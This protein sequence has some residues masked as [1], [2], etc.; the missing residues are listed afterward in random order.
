MDEM[1]SPALLASPIKDATIRCLK[2]FESI[3]D[4]ARSEDSSNAEDNLTRF[5]IWSGNIGAHHGLPSRGSADF[6]LREAP[7]VKSRIL[8]LLDDIAETNNELS[9]IS[10][11]DNDVEFTSDEFDPVEELCLSVSDSITSLMKVSALLRKATNRD[12]YAQALASKHDALPL[13]YAGFDRRHVAEKFPKV[14]QQQWLYDRL[15]NAITVRRRFLRYAQRHQKRIAHEPVDVTAGQPGELAFRLAPS[16]T[17]KSSSAPKTATATALST[18][19]STLQ[20]QKLA[21]LD[22]NRL[23]D[24]DDDNISQATS[25]VSEAGPDDEYMSKVIELDKL[26]KHREPFECPYCHGMVQFRN[27]R[28]WR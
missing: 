20:V 6:R 23:D 22:L 18:A 28:A 24:D 8:E 26:T 27:Q 1:S 3:L 12:R 9:A 2:G 19:A 7:E 5:R 13:E 17:P 10:N 16:Q 14:Q 25:F 11:R 21:G 4:A 15:A